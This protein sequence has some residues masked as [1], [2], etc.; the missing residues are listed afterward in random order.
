T[1][2]PP[3]LATNTPSA[4]ASVPIPPIN[5]RASWGARAPKATP[6]YASSVQ[7]TFVHHTVNSNTYAQS[8]VPS[9]LRSI[10]AY[11]MDSNGWDDIGYNFLVDRFGGMWEGRGGGMDQPVI[12]AH[13][14]GFNTG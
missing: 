6:G 9:I 2:P 11:H 12:G 10:Q 8:D 4:S 14:L 1:G 7:M 3:K 13:T 5:T